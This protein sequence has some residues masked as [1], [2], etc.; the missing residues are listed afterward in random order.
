MLRTAS[1]T[2][3]YWSDSFTCFRSFTASGAHGGGAVDRTVS[4]ADAATTAARRTL[5]ASAEEVEWIGEQRGGGPG[6]KPGNGV[7]VACHRALGRER[8]HLSIDLIRICERT[9][10]QNR[11]QALSSK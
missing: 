11:R 1:N 10:Q 9:K 5:K 8:T 4:T 6:P 2:D 3:L 7:L